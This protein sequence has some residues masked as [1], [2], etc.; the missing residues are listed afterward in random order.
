M[1][2]ALHFLSVAVAGIVVTITAV[3]NTIA[4]A[5]T[6]YITIAMNTNINKF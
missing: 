4:C 3:I 1:Q 2:I 5:H 6:N